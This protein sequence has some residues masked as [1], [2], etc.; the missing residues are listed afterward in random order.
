M[1]IRSIL[2]LNCMKPYAALSHISNANSYMI[3]RE[4][5]RSFEPQIKM[6]G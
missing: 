5:P 6:G 4:K 2:C 3:Y 1:E